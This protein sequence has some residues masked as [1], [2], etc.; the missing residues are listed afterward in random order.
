MRGERLPKGR[1]GRIAKTRLLTGER[2]SNKNLT[3]K[4]D[5]RRQGHRGGGHESHEKGHKDW[6]KRSTTHHQ[7]KPPGNKVTFQRE[8]DA[9]Q[10]EPGPQE[11]A[12]KEVRGSFKT[13]KSVVHEGR[14]V[15]LGER[16][17]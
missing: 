2:N 16:F 15:F 14:G 10:F 11:R 6:K 1:L 5:Y 7:T 3:G 12:E 8:K 4:R 17:L 13:K 9:D